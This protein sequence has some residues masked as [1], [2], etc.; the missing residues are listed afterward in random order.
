MS[1]VVAAIEFIQNGICAGDAECSANVAD[2]WKD[3]MGWTSHYMTHTADDLLCAS[4]CTD[5]TDPADLYL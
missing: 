5:Q 2:V 1:Q 3:Y 4:F